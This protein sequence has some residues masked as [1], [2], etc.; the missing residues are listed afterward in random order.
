M[1]PTIVGSRFSS[2][3]TANHTT[4]VSTTVSSSPHVR[5]GRTVVRGRS[6]ASFPSL[7]RVCADFGVCD[8]VVR[9]AAPAFPQVDVHLCGGCRV[10]CKMIRLNMLSAY[11]KA[12]WFLHASTAYNLIPQHDPMYSQFRWPL[13]TRQRCC[14]RSSLSKIFF[15][16]TFEAT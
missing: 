9:L 2:H 13:K 10:S 6:V 1:R 12:K 3:T 4:T 15:D 5:T 7:A 8:Y 14:G 11:I 16:L